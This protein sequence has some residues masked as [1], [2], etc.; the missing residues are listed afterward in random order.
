MS[1]HVILDTGHL[2]AYLCANDAHHQ[3]AVS[4]FSTFRKPALICEAILI[5]AW[6]LV[7]RRGF[8]ERQ[9]LGMV[10]QGILRVALHLDREILA[11]SA[12][13]DRYDNV[14]MSLADACLVRMA[15]LFPRHR[16]CTLDSDFLIYRKHGR[17]SIDPIIP[18]R[19]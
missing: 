5:E 1:Q 2:V 8:P 14:P 11:L 19:H 4:H 18:P 16:I 17:Q 7:H 13:T 9:L 3:W 12:L 15:E 6:F 10:Q